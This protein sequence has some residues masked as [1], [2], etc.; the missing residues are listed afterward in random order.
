M[1]TETSTSSSSSPKDKNK[2]TS[3][4]SGPKWFRVVSSFPEDRGRVLFRSV[5]E[6]RARAWLSNHFPRGSE[7]HL[8]KPDGNAEHYEHERQG[9]HGQDAD[10]WAEFDPASWKPPAM[11]EPPGQ[12]QWGDVEG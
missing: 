1:S 8:V 3:T 6:K 9:E 7:A 10:Q 11:Q 12:S 4:D 2:D 5:S